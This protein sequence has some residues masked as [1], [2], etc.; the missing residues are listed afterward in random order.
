MGKHLKIVLLLI[1]PLLSA[2][3]FFFFSVFAA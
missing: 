2:T 1:Y 3:N